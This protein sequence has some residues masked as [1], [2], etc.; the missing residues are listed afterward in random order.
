MADNQYCSECEDVLIVRIGRWKENPICS[1]CDKDPDP[2]KKRFIVSCPNCGSERDVTPSYEAGR[3]TPYC[4]H[5]ARYFI[6]R[7]EDAEDIPTRE[8]LKLLA[9]DPQYFLEVRTKLST[10]KVKGYTDVY[11][12]YEH[13]MATS[14]G[15]CGEHRLVMAA[16][17]NRWLTSDESVHHRNGRRSDNRIENLELRELYHGRGHE[18]N[19]ALDALWLFGLVAGEYH[20]G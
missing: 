2:R 10:Q 6:R 16:H 20:H 15:H 18:P 8:D 13:P 3:K 12:G 19:Q 4:E 5:C 14:N 9:S 1:R 17:L 7:G 11:V